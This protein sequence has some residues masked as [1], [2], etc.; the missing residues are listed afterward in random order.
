MS[1][2]EGR[3]PGE[4]W[5]RDGEPDRGA[6]ELGSYTP[7][8]DPRLEIPEVLRTPIDH[9]S[10][11]G[12]SASEAG[13]RDGRGGLGS[14]LSGLGELGKAMAIGFDFL[15]SVIAAALIGYLIDRWQGWSGA[16]LVTGLGIGFAA[17]TVRLIARLNREEARSKS[18]PNGGK[19]R[20]GGPR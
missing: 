6:D 20:S 4:D 2:G 17:G 8:P 3:T 9:P 11:H 16:G 5:P 18:K 14:A 12:R 10:K 1:G 7:A 19:P 15:F 13:G